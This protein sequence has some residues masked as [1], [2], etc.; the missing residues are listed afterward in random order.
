MQQELPHKISTLTRVEGQKADTEWKLWAALPSDCG[1]GGDRMLTAGG[2]RC[3]GCPSRRVE[4]S[5]GAEWRSASVPSKQQRP[6]EKKLLS[7]EKPDTNRHDACEERWC[8]VTESRPWRTCSS[9]PAWTR[10]RLPPVRPSAS[11][12][13]RRPALSRQL[14]GFHGNSPLGGG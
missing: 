11:E 10:R 5:G 1:E 8:D 2:K 13:C 7:V 12:A 4:G 3:A 14:R 6:A 9:L